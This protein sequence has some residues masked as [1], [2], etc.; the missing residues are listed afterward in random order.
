MG[1]RAIIS[2]NRFVSKMRGGSVSPTARRSM[3]LT[4]N[5]NHN[6]LCRDCKKRRNR[7]R[8]TATVALCPFLGIMILL[9]LITG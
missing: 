3:I 2:N 6:C 7:E 4:E 5:H 1:I 8:N 9:G